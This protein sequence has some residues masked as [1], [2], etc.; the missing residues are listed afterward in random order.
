M[1][2][3]EIK[4]LGD[5][6]RKVRK[7]QGLRLED[8]ADDQIS[9]ATISNIERG[10]PHVRPD[11]V[12]YLLQKLEI[13][14][15]KLPEIMNGEQ[16]EL[17][18][19]RFRLMI[20]ETLTDTGRHEEALEQLD[21]A[22]IDDGHLLAPSAYFLRGKVLFRK[23]KWRQAERAFSNGIRLAE[24]QPHADRSN[25]IST[26]YLML[27]LC[28][29]HQ[30]N[31]EKALEHTENGLAAFH[32]DGERPYTI[33]TLLRN[34]AIYLERMGRVVEALKVVEQVWEDL[35][36]IKQMET[37]F[38]FYWL[39]VE[40]LRRSGVLD[41]AVEICME[42]LQ[43]ARLNKEYGALFDLWTVLGSIYIEKGDW[44]NA[45]ACLRLT[46][47]IISEEVQPD[48]L[49]ATYIQLG[50]LYM[51]KEKWEEAENFL[52]KA[53]KN[54][55]EGN[56]MP[57]LTVALLSMGNLYRARNNIE[58]A[59]PYYRRAAQLSKK[60]RLWDKEYESWYRLAQCYQGRDQEAFYRCTERMFTVKEEMYDNQGRM[61]QREGK[62]LLVTFVPAPAPASSL[63]VHRSLRV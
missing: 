37:F 16:R 54:G 10:I 55:E 18:D 40:L 34:K 7:E 3:I 15:D 42:G 11:K 49:A 27:G 63:R 20:I 44:K 53:I 30:N 59:I 6:I 39:K 62:S 52:S 50:L 36:K 32:P 2:P 1:N 17:E 14:M 38:S 21:A 29:Y 51:Y 5:I 9:P 57:H 58:E 43:I 61:L 56:D 41:E 26:C 22:G 25:M 35:P 60:Y 28:S 13:P 4:E 48:R 46:T 47:G 45:E 31:L 19:L 8:L 23:K 33:Y 24:Q 12:M